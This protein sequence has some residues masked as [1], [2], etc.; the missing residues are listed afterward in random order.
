MKTFEYHYKEIGTYVSK[1][2]MTIEACSQE[3]ADIIAE[4]YASWKDQTEHF[5][6]YGNAVIFFAKDPEMETIETDYTSET[7]ENLERK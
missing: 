6:D 5:E 7:F 2:K 1:V 3:E 4:Q